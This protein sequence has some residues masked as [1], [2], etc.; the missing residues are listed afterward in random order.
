MDS[1]AAPIR[2]RQRIE[3][4][5]ERLKEARA[6]IE[7]L[8]AQLRAADMPAL[9]VAPWMSSLRGQE[10]ALIAA[11]NAAHPRALDIYALDEALPRQ[12]HAADRSVKG[13][14]VAIHGV[15]KKL[16]SHV[17]DTVR[18]RGWRLSDAFAADLKALSADA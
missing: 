3:F 17:I 11:L 6:Q 14:H 15:R 5:E 13:V 9:P 18:G 10:I 2:P 4:L 12:D 1:A 7:V 8:I 16:G